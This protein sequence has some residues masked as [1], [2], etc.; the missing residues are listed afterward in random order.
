[1]KDWQ[2]ARNTNMILGLDI[3][4]SITGITIVDDAG[5][6]VYTEAVDTRN[7]NKFDDLLDKVKFIR[8]RIEHVK[9]EYGQHIK[10]IFIEQSLQMFRPGMSS[11]K[12]LTTLSKC[13]GIIAWTCFEYFG[14]K[15]EYIAATSARKLNGIKVPKGSKAKEIVIKHLL[16]NEPDFTVEYT[17]SGNPKPKYYDIADSIVIARAGQVKCSTKN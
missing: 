11:A 16:D 2:N 7:P 14:I 15:P 4:T 3:S 12:T 9:V 10:H 8:K 17:P 6:I 1:M 13:N 5:K